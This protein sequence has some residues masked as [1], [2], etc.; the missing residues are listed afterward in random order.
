[1]DVET[2]S[3]GAREWMEEIGV[4]TVKDG[5]IV[6]EEFMGFAPAHGQEIETKPAEALLARM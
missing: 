6:R 3:T 2:K 5:K 4:Y 1:M